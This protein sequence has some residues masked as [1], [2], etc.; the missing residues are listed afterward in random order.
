MKNIINGIQHIGIPT[1]KWDETISFYQTLGFNSVAYEQN[2]EAQVAFLRCGNLVFEVYEMQKSGTLS[3]AIDHVAIDVKD[4]KQAYE[5]ISNLNLPIVEE[6][7]TFLPFG[8][9][10]VKFFTVVG[11]NQEKIEFNQKL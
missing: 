4:V 8:A 11:P 6:E 9:R 7:I 3:G 5:Y 2:K 1:E 10:G